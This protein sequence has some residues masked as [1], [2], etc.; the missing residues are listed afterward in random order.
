MGGAAR[1]P[2]RLAGGGPGGR[3]HRRG[4]PGAAGDGLRY[5]R[6]PAPGHRA[7]GRVPGADRVRAARL[8]QVAVHGPGGDHR[9]DDPGG[10]QAAGRRAPRPVRQT[11]QYTRPAHRPDGG[12]GLAA[13][14]GLLRGPA[15]AAR[16]GRLHG[17]SGA[18]HDRRSA[19]A[20]DR[21]PGPRPGVLRPGRLVRP[22]AGPHPA[23]GP[24]CLPVCPGVPAA[25]A[26]ALA[27]PAGAVA[28]GAARHRRGGGAAPGRGQPR[29]PGPGPASAG[30]AAH[31]GSRGAARAAASRVHCADRGL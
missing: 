30:R 12:G 28:G 4:L 15:I 9:A 25:A 22:R 24:G 11:R 20:R 13:A 17:G 3:G 14:A 23:D 31:P 5:D 8:V 26:V 16:A 1:I 21:G 10:H 2:P 27:A 19:P 7:V 18:D 29:R 6:R